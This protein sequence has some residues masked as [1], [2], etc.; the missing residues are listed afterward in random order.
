MELRY[1]DDGPGLPRDLDLSRVD[2]LG[3][4]LVHNLAVRQLRGTMELVHDPGTE[5]VFRFRDIDIMKRM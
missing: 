3:L 2:S 1:R 5:F 4:K